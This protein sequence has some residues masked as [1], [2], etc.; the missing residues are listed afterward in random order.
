VSFKRKRIEPSTLLVAGPPAL[1]PS[2]S[3]RVM[4]LIMC[5]ES[6]STA[7]L[8]IY[9]KHPPSLPPSLSPL[10]SYR[11]MVL[12]MRVEPPIIRHQHCFSQCIVS[13]TISLTHLGL[14]FGVGSKMTRLRG[15]EGGEGRGSREEGGGL[16]SVRREG[17]TGVK[18]Y[19]I[20]LTKNAIDA[21]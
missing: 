17:G 8:Q 18:I 10:K 16:V 20:A 4:M 12:Q 19:R 6:T 13:V 14:P 11:V 3:Y 21:S 15:R 7:S 5:V 2:L 9:Y 1:P